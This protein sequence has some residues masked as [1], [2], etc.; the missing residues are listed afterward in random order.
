MA[1]EGNVVGGCVLGRSRQIGEV[2]LG[3]PSST[4]SW[5]LIPICGGYQSAV[6]SGPI[7]QCK[8]SGWKKSLNKQSYEINHGPKAVAKMNPR[9]GSTAFLQLCLMMVRTLLICPSKSQSHMH[10][11]GGV[12]TRPRPCCFDTLWGAGFSRNH[13]KKFVKK[14]K[15]GSGLL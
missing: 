4:E 11:N 1:V 15:K 13:R 8:T 5:F 12:H 14:K 6:K 3:E 9:R 2:S 10:T 7:L